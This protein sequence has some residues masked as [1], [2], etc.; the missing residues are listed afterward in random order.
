M[1]YLKTSA[2]VL[3]NRLENK[4]INRPLLNKLLKE[5]QDLFL[6]NTLIKRKKFY[7]QSNLIVNTDNLSIMEIAEICKSFVLNYNFAK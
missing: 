7:L 3:I 4:L 2:N 1:I 6:K 5:N